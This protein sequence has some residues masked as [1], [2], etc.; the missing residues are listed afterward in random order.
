MPTVCWHC[1]GRCW[2]YGLNETNEVFGFKE[3]K[4]ALIFMFSEVKPN[5]DRG[6]PSMLL[7]CTFESSATFLTVEQFFS[8]PDYYGLEEL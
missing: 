2:V 7:I 3:F 4:K 6:F 8:P 5:C 1:S